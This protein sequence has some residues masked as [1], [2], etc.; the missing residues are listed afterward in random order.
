MFVRRK[1]KKP[2]QKVLDTMREKVKAIAEGTYEYKVP[3]VLIKEAEI[4]IEITEESETKKD[5]VLE[6]AQSKINEAFEADKSS[7]DLGL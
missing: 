7:A 5:S 2:S 3:C 4:E 6:E 1:G